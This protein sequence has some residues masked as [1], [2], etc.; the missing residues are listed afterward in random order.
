MDFMVVKIDGIA[1]MLM[2]VAAESL[3]CRDCT[4]K[5]LISND[6]LYT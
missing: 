5:H 4:D 2:I 1:T 6:I 3:F